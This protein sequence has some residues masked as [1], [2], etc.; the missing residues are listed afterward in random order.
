MTAPMYFVADGDKQAF[1][2]RDAAAF[3]AAG[4]SGLFDDCGGGFAA[5]EI[6]TNGPDGRRGVL[7]CG[8]NGEPPAQWGGYHPKSQTWTPCNVD[9]SVWVGT[10]N[11]EPVTPSDI[12]RPSLIR[13]YPVELG[14]GNTW[15]M[16]TLRFSDQTCGLPYDIYQ[17]ASGDV[18]TEVR[19]EY[20]SLW[21]RSAEMWD[22]MLNNEV[23]GFDVMLPYFVDCLALN[24]RISMPLHSVLRLLTSG[25]WESAIGA[26]LDLPKWLEM[27]DDQKKTHDSGTLSQ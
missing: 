18:Q 9:R 27:L 5:T 8:W 25:N 21:V 24:Y 23:V 2:R 20:R 22:V 12:Q 26:T 1:Q 3:Q 13:G 17:D 11:G 10:F 14:D 7:L 15:V 19:H 16:P 6:R 4:L